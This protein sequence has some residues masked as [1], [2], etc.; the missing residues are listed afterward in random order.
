MQTQPTEWIKVFCDRL[1]DEVKAKPTQNSCLLAYFPLAVIFK[2]EIKW[3]VNVA[4]MKK[5]KR[6]DVIFPAV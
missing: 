2:Y 6:Q 3:K 5:K 1:I 4:H